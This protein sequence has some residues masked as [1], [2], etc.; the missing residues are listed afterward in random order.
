MIVSCK[1]TVRIKDGAGLRLRIAV[2][3]MAFARR[4]GHPALVG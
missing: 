3:E 1:G 4:I 2:F